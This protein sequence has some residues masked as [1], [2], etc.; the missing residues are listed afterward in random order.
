MLEGLIDRGQGALSN[1]TSC[2]TIVGTLGVHEGVPS[3]YHKGF[4]GGGYPPPRGSRS[5]TIVKTL[6]M[7]KIF[8][9]E[10][11]KNFLNGDGLGKF[12]KSTTRSR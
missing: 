1:D 11:M 2:F 9:F 10:S 7:Q 3:G 5:Y 8:D 4:G 6:K 12:S